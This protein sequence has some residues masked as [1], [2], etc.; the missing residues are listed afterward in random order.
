MDGVVKLCKYGHEKTP[1]NIYK[2][3]NCKECQKAYQLA[4]NRFQAVVNQIHPVAKFCQ[5]ALR[6]FLVDHV[7]FSQ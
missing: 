4:Y 7:V 2:N 6:Q 3:G 1:E 5:H